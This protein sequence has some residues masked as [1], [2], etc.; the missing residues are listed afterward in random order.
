MA[1]QIFNQAVQP[2]MIVRFAQGEPTETTLAW[3]HSECEG[4]ANLKD[5]RA[6]KVPEIASLS[7]RERCGTQSM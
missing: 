5:H 1:L 7:V 4:C 3:P 6:A 2:K